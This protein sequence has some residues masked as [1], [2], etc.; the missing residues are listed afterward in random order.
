MRLDIVKGGW[1]GAKKWQGLAIASVISCWLLTTEAQ[2][3]SWVTSSDIS[4]GLS[5]TEAF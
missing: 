1:G 3:Q 5:R 4:D 2:V